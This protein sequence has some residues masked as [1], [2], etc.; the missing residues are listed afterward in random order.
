MSTGSETE[1]LARAVAVAVGI[2]LAAATPVASGQAGAVDDR[3]QELERKLEESARRLGELER[4]I[5]EQQRRL[6]ASSRALDLQLRDE[7]E[8]R[9][10]SGRGT[11]PGSAAG[12][13][14]S[15]PAVGGS[16][17]AVATPGMRAAPDPARSSAMTPADSVQPQG[18]RPAIRSAQAQ[19]APASP[20]NQPAAQGSGGAAPG[21]GTPVGEAP[22]QPD[23]PAPAAQI[24]DEPTALTPRGKFV[25]EPAYQFVHSTD[26]RIALVGYSV[27]PAIT[28]DLIDVR[29]VSR[30]IHTLSLTGRYG[31]TP[32]FELEAKVPWVWASS[33]TQTRPLAT[34]SVTD[35]FFDSDGSGLGDVELAARYQFNQFRGD[36]AVYIGYLRY[37][38]RTGEGVFEVPIDPATGLQEELPTGS[39]FHGLQAGLTFLY[40]S[41]PAVFFGGLAYMHNFS[42]D[43]GNG[44]GRIDPGG[45]FDLN[46]GMGLA[47][48]ERS[49]FS[50]GYQHSVVG[51]TKQ[52]DPEEVA[53]VLAESGRLQLGTLRFG[54]AYRLSAKQNVNLSLG[55]GVTDDSP[56][57]ELTLRLP[58]SF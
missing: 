46:L 41:D 36:N 27:I 10:L 7:T 53:R 9:G 57:V 19:P 5:E 16:A 51:K 37:K 21:P 31:V 12:S 29:R 25:L 47:L 14:A 32:R 30:D 17:G 13:A 2:G 4:Q 24:F 43:V 35:S 39:G 44:F 38:S 42:R 52:R 28:I 55:I 50:I 6:D 15:V 54:I 49:S 23:R 18:A 58:M 45:V 40:P 20:A 11:A 1:G 34:P 8:L 48:N 33:D 3:V 56:D 22:Q 26:N